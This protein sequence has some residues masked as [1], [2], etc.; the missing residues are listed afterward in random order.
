MIWF[1]VAAVATSAALSVLL[2]F[3]FLQIQE[4][5]ASIQEAQSSIA[6]LERKEHELTE[7]TKSLDSLKN[8]RA[9]LEDTF[10]SENTFV[11]FIEELEQFA[12]IAGVAFQAQGA[13]LSVLPKG[14]KGNVSSRLSFELKGNFSGMYRFFVLLDQ[15]PEA[16]ILENATLVPSAKSESELRA[17]ARYIILNTLR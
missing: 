8:D 2:V 1:L 10:V 9:T 5:S 7:I 11:R 12:R 13:D 15:A 6:L 4:R 16:G 3:L 17:Q 14:G